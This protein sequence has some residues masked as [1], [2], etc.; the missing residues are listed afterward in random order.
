MPPSRRP[1][2]PC[3]G[4]NG[5]DFVRVIPREFT[6][7]NSSIPSIA[8]MTATLL[9]SAVKVLWTLVPVQPDI[10]AGLGMLEIIIC[11]S[12][13]FAEWYCLDVEHIPIGPE[14]MTERILLDGATPYR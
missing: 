2:R 6:Q 7:H 3:R 1:A 8:P 13:G 4:C 12:C 14:C 10:T 5:G 9:P 11:R